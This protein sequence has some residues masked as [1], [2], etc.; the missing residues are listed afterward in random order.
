MV[1][2]VFEKKRERKDVKMIGEKKEVIKEEQREY[3]KKLGYSKIIETE[4]VICIIDKRKKLG[5]AIN[6]TKQ[7]K[8]VRKEDD[9]GQSI[10][11]FPKEIVGVYDILRRI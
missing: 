10:K 6:I 8:G 9:L 3:F 2:Y 5:C 1:I 4:K 11:M 7:D